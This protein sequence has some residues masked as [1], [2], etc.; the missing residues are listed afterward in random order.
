MVAEEDV[1]HAARRRGLLFESHEEV[2]DVLGPLAPVQNVAELDEVGGAALP[3]K[4]G[5][6]QVDLGVGEDVD[7]PVVIAVQVGHGHNVV[8]ARPLA[9]DVGGGEEEGKEGEGQEQEPAFRGTDAFPG[10]H[11]RLLWPFFRGESRTGRL[12]PRPGC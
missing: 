5:V 6:D 3:V 2:E 7:E 9:G 11:L 12:T 8:D 10:H 4:V 1:D